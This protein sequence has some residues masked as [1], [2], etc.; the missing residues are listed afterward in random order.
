MLYTFAAELFHTKKLYSRLSTREIH[1]KLEKRS[2]FVFEQRVKQR[3]T[4]LW[5]FCR[6]HTETLQVLQP[7]MLT[8]NDHILPLYCIILPKGGGA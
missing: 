4:T 6:R 5:S 8:L 3:G 7:V 1:F 2:L